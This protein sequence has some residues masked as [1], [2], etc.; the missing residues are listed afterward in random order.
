MCTINIYAGNI[1]S[2]LPVLRFT[3]SY[4]SAVIYEYCKSYTSI[5]CNSILITTGANR[6]V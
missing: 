5:M 3:W 4:S 2:I 6:I 1:V